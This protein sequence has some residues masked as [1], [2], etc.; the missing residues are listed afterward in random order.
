MYY[1]HPAFKPIRDFLLDPHVSE[2]MVNGPSQVFI[3]RKGRM[4]LTACRFAGGLPTDA[5]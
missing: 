5:Y 1:D 2:I 3:E 4:E